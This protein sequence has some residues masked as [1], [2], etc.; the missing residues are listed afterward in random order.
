MLFY[1]CYAIIF[2]L[3]SPVGQFVSRILLSLRQTARRYIIKVK[4]RR[5]AALIDR[6]RRAGVGQ[7]A[8]ATNRLAMDQMRRKLCTPKSG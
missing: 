7:R 3:F 1:A 6:Q 5:S 4:G 2:G 8:A